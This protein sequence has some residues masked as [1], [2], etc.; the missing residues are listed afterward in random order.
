MKMQLFPT[1][2]REERESLGLT[3]DEVAESAGISKRSYCA[4]EAGET[5]PSAKLLSALALMGADVSYLL[6]GTRGRDVSPSETVLSDRARLAAAIGAVEEGLAET[7]RKLPPE[8]RA[9]LI[10]AAYDLLA[11]SKNSRAKVIRLV[12]NAA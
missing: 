3:Q 9:E 11:E 5:A 4:Y 2:L 6:T 1:L 10:L 7:R 12:R 8:K